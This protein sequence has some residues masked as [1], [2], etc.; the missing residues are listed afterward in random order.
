MLPSMGAFLTYM[1]GLR[2]QN[3]LGFSFGSYG[4]GGQAM[5]QI[6]DVMKELKWELPEPGI[7]VKYVPDQEDL[8]KVREAGA[9]LASHIK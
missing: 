3:R 1:K 9:R 4:W 8:D 2:P 6:E 7:N 5:G